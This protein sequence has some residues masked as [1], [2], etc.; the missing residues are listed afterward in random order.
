MRDLHAMH[1]EKNVAKI[2]SSGM[3]EVLDET[4]MPYD[5]YFE[6]ADDARNNSARG[7]Y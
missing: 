5:L 6:D 3:A 1:M 4:F 7:R 2:S